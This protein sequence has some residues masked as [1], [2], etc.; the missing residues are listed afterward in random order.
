MMKIKL[1]PCLY[2]MWATATHI[3]MFM[4]KTGNSNNG[5]KVKKRLATS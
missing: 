1:S 4:R 2:K 5:Y 3:H